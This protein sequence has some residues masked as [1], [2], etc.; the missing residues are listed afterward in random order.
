[1]KGHSLMIRSFQQTYSI[2][3]CTFVYEV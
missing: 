3:C 2:Q 1:V